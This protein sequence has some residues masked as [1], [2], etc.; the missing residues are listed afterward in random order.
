MTG[1][2]DR[3]VTTAARTRHRIGTLRVGQPPWVALHLF[4]AYVESSCLYG[5]EIWAPKLMVHGGQAYV[6][7]FEKV[8]LD[9]VKRACGI[10]PNTPTAVAFAEL[11]VR[12]L[13]D[14]CW[15]RLIRFWN[16]LAGAS[17]DDM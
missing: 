10:A 13:M 7:A 15:L 16:E 1:K 14:A 6:K 12:P 4:K 17:D 8:Q 9:F 5:S 2:M 11:Q 3:A